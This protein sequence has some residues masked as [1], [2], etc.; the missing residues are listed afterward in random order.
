MYTQIGKHNMQANL[1]ATHLGLNSAFSAS[2]GNE[3][4]GGSYARQVIS[5]QAPANGTRTGSSGTFT[6]PAGSTVAWKTFWDA[7]SGGNCL[8]LSP[9]NGTPREYHVDISNNLVEAPG[10]GWSNG[11]RVVFYD[12]AVPAP[13]VEGTIYW[14]VNAATDTFQ[15]SSTQGGAAIVLTT[16]GAGSSKV[17]NI[18]PET[19]TNEGQATANSLTL[20][21]GF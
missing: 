8:A 2:G 13:L 3:I 19:F 6:V 11:Q 14:V 21:L 5:W 17:S 18:S 10:H 9:L 15:V 12:G 20:A 4:S 7:A 1:G 16:Q